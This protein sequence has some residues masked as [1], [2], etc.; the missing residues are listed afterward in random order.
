MN[1]QQGEQPAFP[2]C[3]EANVNQTMGMTM[4]DWFAGQALQGLLAGDD[5]GWEP[6]CAARMA[7]ILADEML[8]CRERK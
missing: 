6:D 2:A 4:R 1:N 7:Y 3:N 8:K 5:D